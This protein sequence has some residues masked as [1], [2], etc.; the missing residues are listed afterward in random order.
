MKGQNMKGPGV[1][2]VLAA[3]VATIPGPF[4]PYAVCAS[5]E[6]ITASAPSGAAL[7]VTMTV[8]CAQGLKNPAMEIR[9]IAVVLGKQRLNPDDAEAITNQLK[10]AK[11]VASQQNKHVAL[12]I[13]AY[14][15]LNVTDV[16]NLIATAAGAGIG[17]ITLVATPYEAAK[18]DAA[19]QAAAVEARL[20]VPTPA[21]DLRGPKAVRVTV[22][23]L[24]KDWPVVS[25]IY[26]IWADP[27]EYRRLED[28]QP[29]LAQ[30]AEK[31]GKSDPGLLAT[32]QPAEGVNW[33]ALVQTMDA[34]A[35][36]GFERVV[37]VPSDTS[38]TATTG[39]GG[40]KTA[41]FGLDANASHIVFVI[42]RSGSMLD[43]FDYVRKE[44]LNSISRLKK[45][46]D[47]HVI[48]YA[49]GIPQENPPQQLVLAI[50]DNK[51]AA[52]D[53]LNTIRPEGQTNPLPAIKRAFEVLD[54]ADPK[55][56]GKII[57]LLTDGVFPD[58]DAV[59]KLL[60]QL[61]AKKEVH[62]HTILYGDKSEDAQKVLKKIADDSGGKFRQVSNDD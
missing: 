44:M 62:V 14:G 34:V 32:V 57:Y 47:F 53:F 54:K 35:K 31:I 40:A 11:L 39:P 52:A 16:Q 7:A 21:T 8:E 29:K 19:A 36:A 49:A 24:T 42:D 3:V 48:F 41:F 60:K 28:L 23:A 10:V 26:E 22:R 37:L 4:A 6:S 25:Y 13:S 51:S 1:T 43:A 55:K 2:I 59:I 17:D 30:R 50:D 45:D 38:K 61:N 18:G 9:P 15:L 58:N 56:A 46:Q 5:P 12:R 33:L 20:F 27:I